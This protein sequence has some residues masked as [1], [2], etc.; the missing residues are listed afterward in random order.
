MIRGYI[1]RRVTTHTTTK[2]ANIVSQIFWYWA[3]FVSFAAY[4]KEKEI[5]LGNLFNCV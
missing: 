2:M 1:P 5:Q 3:Y 4:K